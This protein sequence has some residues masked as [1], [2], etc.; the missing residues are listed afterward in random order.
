[1]E[2]LYGVFV[3]PLIIGIVA[4]FKQAGLNQKYAGIISWL[5]GLAIG[6]AY[7]LTEGG[8]TLLQC[9]V[10]GSMLGLSASGLYSTQKNARKT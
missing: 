9:I 6:L 8:W 10:V 1:M 4:L 2:E 5:F 3:V 7:G